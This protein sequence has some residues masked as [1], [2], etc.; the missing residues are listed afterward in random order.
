MSLLRS[1]AHEHTQREVCT[2][3]GVQQEVPRS[4]ELLEA[5]GGGQVV[6]VLVRVIPG[7]ELP[8]AR[9]DVGVPERGALFGHE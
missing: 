2:H 4:D 8:E 9:A 6:G 7:R 1:A 3:L 5:I